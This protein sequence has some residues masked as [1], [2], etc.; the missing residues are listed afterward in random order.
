MDLKS[1]LNL[2]NKT[3]NEAV[4]DKEAFTLEDRGGEKI[5]TEK[6]TIWRI[7]KRLS[8]DELHFDNSIEK[9]FCDIKP[10]LRSL[11]VSDDLNIQ[12]LLFFDIEST[13]LSTG[14][15][16][17][18]FLCGF[19]YMDDDDFITE[20]I[21]MEKYSDE[22][23]VLQYMLSL[24]NSFK[25]V[26]TFNG[27][28]FDIPLIKNRYMINRV[29]GFPMN[30][31]HIDLIVPARRIFRSVYESCSLGSLEN[32]LIGLKRE[33]DI[34]GWLIPEVYFTFQKTG[35]SARLK[36][37]INHNRTDIISMIFLMYIFAGIF[38]KVEKKDYSELSEKSLINIAKHLFARNLELFLDLAEFLGESVIEDNSLFFKY[39]L[40]LKKR[41]EY[42]KAVEYW[43]KSKSVYSYI[44]LAKFYEHREKNFA[45]A[46]ESCSA[47]MSLIRNNDYSSTKKISTEKAAIRYMEDCSKRLERLKQKA[48]NIKPQI[49]AD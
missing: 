11:S 23:A 27:K 47:A 48:D 24:F 49:N 26:V 38:D 34:E 16:N 21:F 43:D 44:E 1:K 42:E 33:D 45:K 30:I 18:P 6:G 14:T 13:S 10:L 28:T 37:V 15:G 35:E 39:S 29:Y 9:F 46:V 7:E 19:G 41:D 3:K 8:F 17:Y 36:E 2:Y 25:T 40:V 22:P 4:T 20:Q 12:E 32:N 5:T 31:Q